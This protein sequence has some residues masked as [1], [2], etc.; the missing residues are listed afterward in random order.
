MDN[1]TIFAL[2]SGSLPSGVAVI[3]ISGPQCSDVLDCFAVGNLDPRKAKLS[4]LCCPKSGEKIDQG[5][6]LHFP[7]PESFTGED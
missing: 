1:D 2:S 4:I 3:R 5:L 6:V 7:G